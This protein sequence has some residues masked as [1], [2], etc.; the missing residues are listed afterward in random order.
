MRYI[1]FEIITGPKP[2]HSY[3]VVYFEVKNN[4]YIEEVRRSHK[5]STTKLV[6]AINSFLN[7]PYPRVLVYL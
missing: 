4:L 6:I 7:Y 3:V 1:S 5:V 2:Y